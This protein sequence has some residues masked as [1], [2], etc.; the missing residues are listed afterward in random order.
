MGRV[1]STMPRESEIT[2]AIL[3][4]LNARAGVRAVKLHGSPYGRAGTPDVL[5]VTRGRAVFLEVKRPG[6]T[7]TPLQNHELQQWALAGA[8]A[9]VVH[10]KDEAVAVIDRVAAGG[11][12]DG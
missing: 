7:P 8:A 12:V 6:N 5:A 11:T 3:A 9:A 2:R 1:T 4:A 10:S